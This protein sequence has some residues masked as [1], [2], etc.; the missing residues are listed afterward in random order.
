MAIA[1]VTSILQNSN[2]LLGDISEALISREAKEDA[3]SL[4]KLEEAK[5]RKA[6]NK[7]MLD[8]ILALGAVRQPGGKTEEKGGFLSKILPFA[9]GLITSMFAAIFGKAG[10]ISQLFS[11]IFG[12][13]GMLSKLGATLSNLFGKAGKFSKF[14]SVLKTLLGPLKV[15][16]RV[17][18]L[19]VT[20]I[21]ALIGAI[22][23]FMAAYAVDGDLL[24]GIGGALLGLVDGLVGWVIELG[25]WLLGWI[26]E[27]LGFD[28]GIVDQFKN[29]DFF[30]WATNFFK[31]IPAFVIGVVDKVKAWVKENITDKL[32]H[33]LTQTPFGKK[34]TEKIKPFMDFFG[35]VID[36]VGD[37]FTAIKDGMKRGMA[38]AVVA[39]QKA[40]PAWLTDNII[41]DK[42]L[43]WLGL[44]TKE[45]QDLG[46]KALSARDEKDADLSQADRNRLARSEQTRAEKLRM[47]DPILIAEK[48]KLAKAQ[49]AF[50]AKR[51]KLWVVKDFAN[52]PPIPVIVAPTNNSSTSTQTNISTGTGSGPVKTIDQF[53]RRYDYKQ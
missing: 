47:N 17:L 9:I 10:K 36:M 22:K 5:E 4:Q 48:L 18:G 39:A 24:A 3:G 35:K 11:G 15:L 32:T 45:E 19:P 31:A 42:A 29:F 46:G 25:A 1:D 8:A 41:P 26:L 34:L 14:G 6:Q 37:I 52:A 43:R 20:V 2:T 21:M 33:F 30:E 7:K 28:K 50:E 12:K 27:K 53:M 49:E 13:G 23:G 51:A 38:V 44:P 16:I 40:L